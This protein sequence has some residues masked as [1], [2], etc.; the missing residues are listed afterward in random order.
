MTGVVRPGCGIRIGLYPNRWL[1]SSFSSAGFS[2]I[3]GTPPPPPPHPR[4]PRPRAGGGGHRGTCSCPTVPAGRFQ[5]LNEG[6][7]RLGGQVLTVFVVD[8]AHRRLVARPEALMGPVQ[9][10]L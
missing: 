8:P 6:L 5:L 1:T 7:G 10:D 9:F 4:P 2:S 3:M